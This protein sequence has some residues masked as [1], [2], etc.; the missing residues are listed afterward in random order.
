MIV[1]THYE[2]KL[3]ELDNFR[4]LAYYV[5]APHVKKPPTPQKFLSDVWPSPR[6]LKEKA[7]REAQKIE[8]LRKELFKVNRNK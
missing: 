8:R 7:D 3:D 2:N 6:D 1:E 4:M 5:Y